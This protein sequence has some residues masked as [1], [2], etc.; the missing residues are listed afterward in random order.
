MRALY[1]DP[2][3]PSRPSH[4]DYRAQGASGG[5]LSGPTTTIG[6]TYFKGPA[7]VRVRDTLTAL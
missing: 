4:P 1:F 3:D 5:G 6:G 2:D 7:G